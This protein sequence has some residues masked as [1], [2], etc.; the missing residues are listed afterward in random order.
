[1]QDSFTILIVNVMCDTAG[2][3]LRSEMSTLM[4]EEAVLNPLCKCSSVN[5][6][7]TFEFLLP[8]IPLAFLV[9]RCANTL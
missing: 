8:L 4:I 2:L 7:L 9:V 6:L 3:S 5:L 1:M